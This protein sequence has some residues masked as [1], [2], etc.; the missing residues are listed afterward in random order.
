M[1]NDC[2]SFIKFCNER[3]ANSN[4]YNIARTIINHIEDIKIL[5][6]EK[7]AEEA[8]ISPAS[9]SR[10]INKAGFESFQ[11]FKYEFELFTRDVKMR[12]I[13]SHT[14]RFMRTTIEN[15]SESYEFEK[16]YL[17]QLDHN[18]TIVFIGVYKEW[19]SDAQKEILDY[20]KERKIKIIAFVQEE[21]YLKEYADL[22]YVYGIPDSYNDGYYSL[23]Y[24]NRLLCEMIYFK[25]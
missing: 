11:A 6:L 2:F 21:D 19:F 9:V 10:F 13:I 15:M 12:R 16:M 1:K 18:D 3:I 7:I 4:D 25:L 22:L 23:P 17:N 14:Q 8:N 5:S 20:A 24:L